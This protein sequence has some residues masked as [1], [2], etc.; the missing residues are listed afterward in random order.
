MTHIITSITVDQGVTY[1]IIKPARPDAENFYSHNGMERGPFDGK[2][3]TEAVHEWEKLEGKKVRFQDQKLWPGI[4]SD[5]TYSIEPMS[6]EVKPVPKFK[7]EEIGRK[8]TRPQE[9]R[10]VVVINHEV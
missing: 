9:F 8:D 6:V 3:F 2:A 10:E 1:A 5:G 7:C 4:S